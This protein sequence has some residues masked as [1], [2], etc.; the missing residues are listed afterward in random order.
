MAMAATCQQPVFEPNSTNPRVVVPPQGY[1]LSR[2][3]CMICK[4]TMVDPVCIRRCC[5][6]FCAACARQLLEQ[7]DASF[8]CPGC[9][10]S[11]WAP[12]PVAAGEVAGE[13]ARE[14]ILPRPVDAAEAAGV[15]LQPNYF[16]RDFLDMVNGITRHHC[17]FGCY[18]GVHGNPVIVPGGEGAGACGFTGKL[19]EV[20]EHE[21]TCSYKRFH[22]E[23]CACV[24]PGDASDHS[25]R[26]RTSIDMRSNAVNAVYT[27]W[28]KCK[29]MFRTS[30]DY[31]ASIEQR[32]HKSAAVLRK[33]RAETSDARRYAKTLS[34]EVGRL[35][36][37]VENLEIDRVD[38]EVERDA[39][40]GKV[41]KAN[42]EVRAEL[43]KV[44]A[45]LDKVRADLDK[46][47]GERDEGRETL[48]IIIDSGI[49]PAMPSTKRAKRHLNF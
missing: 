31:V 5:H 21:K 25:T 33:E 42:E 24:V 3:A 23:V 10:E 13:M 19:P 35:G 27:E 30:G 49:E 14:W 16:A 17:K 22:C 12:M 1:D 28:A 37:L 45:E 11:A 38:R 29:S 6:S 41:T 44:R 18:S 47:V 7:G 36:I 43:D 9:N 26:S 4:G 46:A 2:F 34:R 40:L 39:E 20:V 48:Q 8:V 15:A 32:V